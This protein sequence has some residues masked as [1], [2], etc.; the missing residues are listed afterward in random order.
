MPLKFDDCRDCRF[1]RKPSICAECDVG[2][3]YEDE[4]TPTVDEVFIGVSRHERSVSDD[5]MGVRFDANRFVDDL[6]DKDE[7]DDEDA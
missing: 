5:D 2:E 3:L 1:R 7:A 6:E 4:D